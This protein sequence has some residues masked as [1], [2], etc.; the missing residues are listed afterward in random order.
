MDRTE[1]ENRRRGEVI[2]RDEWNV[3]YLSVGSGMKCVWSDNS[4]NRI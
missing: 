3:R 2:Y 4:M 1:E